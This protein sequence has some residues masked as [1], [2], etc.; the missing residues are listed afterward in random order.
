MSEQPYTVSRSLSPTILVV[1][2]EPTITKLCKEILQQTGFS[3]LV[4][5]GSSEALKICTQHKE[6]IDLLLTDLILPPPGFQ[7]ASSSN[8]FPHVHGH[9]LVVRALR[10]RKELR[11]IL[12][13]GNIDQDLAGYGIRRGDLPF[14]PKPFEPQVLVTLVRQ[15]LQ[16]PPPSVENLIAGSSGIQQVNDGW[17]D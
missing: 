17:V 3:V 5:D 7:L 13:S 6:S 4:A 10:I 15:I 16:T 9:E 8:P 1:D 12:M 14:L 11:V 2:D